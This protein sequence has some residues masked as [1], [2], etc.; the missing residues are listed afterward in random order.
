M[1]N[2]SADKTEDGHNTEDRDPGEGQPPTSKEMFWD[3]ILERISRGKCTPFLGAGACYGL[4]PLAADL[5]KELSS[6]YPE[7]VGDSDDLARVSQFIA[8][9]HDSDTPKYTIMRLFKKYPLPSGIDPG[10][11][12]TVLA[13]L[14]LPVYIT[15][16]YDNFMVEALKRCDKDPRRELCRWNSYLIKHEHSIFDKSY[17]P[18]YEPTAANPV[19]F[20]LHGTID[21][22][23]SM[24]LTEDDQID[25]LIN[26][27][28]HLLTSHRAERKDLMIPPRIEKALGGT[29][30]L[31]LGY[32]LRDWDFR[33]LFRTLVG[34]LERSAA[35]SHISVQLAPDEKNN[36]P[37]QNAKVKE[38]LERYFN[39][40]NI[41]LYWG[42][43]RQFV[44]EL[45]EKW[46]D[47][48]AQNRP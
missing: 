20:H 7:L 33:V 27:Q 9:W 46:K 40:Q 37:E 18:P 22:S 28:K 13:D 30:V 17:E 5:A 34:S 45:N 4:I 23:E 1:L 31:F 21:I 3:T 44:E 48:N 32:S 47:Y 10:E 39:K 16:N 43:C 26:Y 25:F 6:A 19:V 24:V 29:T 15:T 11:P 38:H 36:S 35:K 41:T 8:T 42:T 12:H 14:P 2:V